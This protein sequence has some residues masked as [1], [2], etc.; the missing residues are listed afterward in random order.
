M[1]ESTLL[2]P[3]TWWMNSPMASLTLI[4][5]NDAIG[6]KERATIKK[7]SN[8]LE[9]KITCRCQPET[10]EGTFLGALAPV[11][12]QRRIFRSQENWLNFFLFLSLPQPI[13]WREYVSSTLT[14]QRSQAAASLGSVE[15]NKASISFAQISGHC[16]SPQREFYLVKTRQRWIM[17]LT[18]LISFLS[19]YHQ[20][21]YIVKRTN[22]GYWDESNCSNSYSGSL[23]WR[24]FSSRNRPNKW[25]C[26]LFGTHGLQGWEK[27][28]ATK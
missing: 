27:G 9:N 23:D 28:I 5:W 7:Q 20:D 21:Y 17:K 4:S 12:K 13:D 11:W 3:G 6:K 1:S 25:Y 18:P 10:S 26:S 15:T 14:D 16:N 24:W 22:C 8:K 2:T 19:A